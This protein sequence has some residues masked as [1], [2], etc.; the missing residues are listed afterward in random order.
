[1]TARA[2]RS[3]RRP[4]RAS[5]L[6]RRPDAP[7]EGCRFRTRRPGR[8]PRSATAGD[9]MGRLVGDAVV[10]D[11][12]RQGALRGG[13]PVSTSARRMQRRGPGGRR[14]PRSRTS[15]SFPPSPT[16]PSRSSR[17]RARR[18]ASTTRPQP[19][20][21][22]ASPTCAPTIPAAWPDDDTRR[23]VIR[24]DERPTPSRRPDRPAAPG[25]HPSASAGAT[26]N[27]RAP[28]RRHLTRRPPSLPLRR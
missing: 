19:A 18:S 1:M 28:A 20:R 15:R 13:V 14:R 21:T 5:L 3:V 23:R 9:P 8:D 11:L 16:S 24:R 6:P 17:A 10:R 25:S 7:R 26:P 22:G 27:P 4:A 12:R 2:R